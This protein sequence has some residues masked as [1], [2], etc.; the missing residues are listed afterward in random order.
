VGV[1]GG[2]LWFLGPI[3]ILL[4]MLALRDLRLH[5]TKSGKREAWAGLVGGVLG[6]AILSIVVYITK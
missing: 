4:A 6:T 2:L 3:A 5:P 1:A